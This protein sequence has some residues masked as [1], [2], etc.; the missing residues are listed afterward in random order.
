VPILADKLLHE[1]LSE[2]MFVEVYMIAGEL[3]TLPKI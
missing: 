1:I 3:G 2:L